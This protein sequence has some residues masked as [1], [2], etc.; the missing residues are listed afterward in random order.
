MSATRLRQAQQ[1]LRVG[2]DGRIL[3][4]RPK[5]IARYIWELC[6][7]L[8]GLMPQ[9]RFFIYAPEAILS[10]VESS[11]WTVRVDSST[12]RKL[13]KA[14]WLA[15]RTGLVSREDKLDV[16]WGT[17]GL[18]PLAW[19]KARTVLTVHDIVHRVAPETMS[20]RALWMTRLFF[21]A[22]LARADAITANSLGTASRLK[23]IFGYSV[24]A[25]VNP[26]VSDTFRPRGETEI[27][28]ALVRHKIYKP[29]LLS[30]ATRE[31]RKNLLL[32]TDTFVRM[33][34][35]NLIPDHKLVLVGDRGWKD[36]SIMNSI[37]RGSSSIMNLG[38][39]DDDELAALYS[40]ADAFVFPSK[41]EGFGMP[42]LEARACGTPVITTNIPEL[43]EAGG[44]NTV[45][46]SPTI[47][48]VRQGILS[49]LRLQARR[50]FDCRMQSWDESA[51]KLAAILSDG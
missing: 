19:L 46:V 30:V 39:V 44:E 25:I 40:G 15:M 22:S 28:A 4:P 10:P 48:G 50:S 24:A 26:A 17:T 8:D 43:R 6:R 34:T 45:Y 33:Q 14:L 2:I 29:Y 23:S 35:E 5:G 32:L 51:A 3:G 47:D 41:Y 1:C 31:P 36:K 9:A 38:Y 42:V 16:F 13:P 21:S 7:S 49:V 11:R 18:L 27:H 20:R 37:E 12:M